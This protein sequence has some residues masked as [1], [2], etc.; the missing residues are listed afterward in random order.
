MYGATE[1]RVHA[2]ECMQ[3]AGQPGL[4]RSHQ[5]DLLLMAA[6]WLE[7]AEIGKPTGTLAEIRKT[8]G[9]SRKLLR[10]ARRACETRLKRK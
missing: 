4:S 10:R 9:W 8:A 3:Q 7:L 5:E 6:Q 2:E 1:F